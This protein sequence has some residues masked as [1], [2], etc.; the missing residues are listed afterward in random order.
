MTW[1]R[2]PYHIALHIEVVCAMGSIKSSNIVVFV[3]YILYVYI[4]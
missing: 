3:A 1:N 4:W 2:D